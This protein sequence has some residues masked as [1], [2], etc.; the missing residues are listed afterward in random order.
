VT[1]ILV[2]ASVYAI[3]GQ[4]ALRLNADDCLPISATKIAK[5]FIWSDVVTFLI[6]SG[7]GGMQVQQS[8]SITGSKVCMISIFLS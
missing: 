8:L 3:L 5:Y 1:L 6:Q 2:L 7:G 4:M